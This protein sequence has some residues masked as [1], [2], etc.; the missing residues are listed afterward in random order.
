VPTGRP[1]SRATHFGCWR[2]RMPAWQTRRTRCHNAPGRGPACSGSGVGMSW[3]KRQP[4]CTC[5]VHKRARPPMATISAVNSVLAFAA[6]RT[7][8]PSVWSN[9][10]IQGRFRPVA[11]QHEPTQDRSCQSMAWRRLLQCVSQE[12]AERHIG[13]ASQV[14]G[15]RQKSDP[16]R[17]FYS[18][19]LRQPP[20]LRPPLVQHPVAKH[21][22]EDPKSE[23]GYPHI[24]P[25]R[26]A[27]PAEPFR[28]IS[29]ELTGSIIVV[30]RI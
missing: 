16:G 10:C 3:Q 14:S 25:S 12:P 17:S 9:A 4:C 26:Q 18:S 30:A 2:A 28:A 1:R 15:P 20:T 22:G 21:L 13:S 19:V 24:E 6:D 27:L 7:V 29:I 23:P 11:N 5:A 8:R